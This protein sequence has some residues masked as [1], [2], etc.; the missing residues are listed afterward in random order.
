MQIKNGSLSL[1][2]VDLS[3]LAALQGDSRRTYTSIGEQLGVSHSTIYDRMKKMEARGVIRSY[4]VVVDSEKMGMR[5]ITALV[6]V[7]ANPRESEEVAEKLCMVPQVLEVYTSVS[8]ELSIIAKVVADSQEMLHDLI[9]N[10]VAPIP[11]VLRIRT[12][13]V[14]KK[15]KETAFAIGDFPKRLTTVNG[16]RVEVE[17]SDFES[18]GKFKDP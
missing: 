18:R 10:S 1:D 17:R 13:I 11:G 8:D 2:D 3:I 16:N 9:A 7:M 4:T 5:R 12:A 6:T 14:A 15:F